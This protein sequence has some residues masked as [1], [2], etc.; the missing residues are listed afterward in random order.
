MRRIAIWASFCLFLLGSTQGIGHAQKISITCDPN[1]PGMNIDLNLR[2]ADLV[3]VLSAM[4]KA[5]GDRYQLQVGNGVAG[6]IPRVQLIKCPF[7]KALDAILGTEYSYQC[8]WIGYE[9]YLYTITGRGSATVRSAVHAQQISIT[10]DPNSPEIKMDISL[11]DADLGEV[12]T[13]MF[14]ATGAEVGLAG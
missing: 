1:S 9:Q 13:A 12:L 14:N 8:R 6:H 2:K 11:R 7:D 10:C 5:T 3:E 4:F